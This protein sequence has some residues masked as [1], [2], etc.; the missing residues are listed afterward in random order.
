MLYFPK[1]FCFP[2][3]YRC[4]TE[5][6]VVSAF[7]F[8]NRDPVTLISLTV[9]VASAVISTFRF[10]NHDPV[11]LISL[12]VIVAIPALL[13]SLYF[14]SLIKIPFVKINTDKFIIAVKDIVVRNRVE[15][16]QR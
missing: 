6:G 13:P 1:H 14:V 9:I 3:R 2:N 7:R 10:R 4:R 8:L 15:A 11:T 16:S 5:A 12:I